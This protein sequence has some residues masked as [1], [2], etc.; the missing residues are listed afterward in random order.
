MK[1]NQKVAI[2]GSG[3]CGLY[4]AWKLSKQGHDISVFEK[5]KKIGKETCSGLFSKRILKFVPESKQLIQNRIDFVL[6]HFPKRTIKVRFSQKFFVMSHLDLDKLVASLAKRSGAKIFLNQE[7]R[8]LPRG[9]DQIIGCD[10]VL[11][12]VRKSLGIKNPSFRLAIQGFVKE[13]CFENFVEVWP[14]VN[15]GF[16]WR[17]PRGKEIEYGI[18]AKPQKAKEYFNRFL[19]KNKLSL[20]KIRSALVPQGFSIPH[21]PTVTLCGDAAGITKPWSGGGVIWGLIAADILLKH[22]PNFFNYQKAMKKFFLPKIIFSKT[23][24]TLVY[25]LGFNMPWILPQNIKMESDF[26]L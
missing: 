25:F 17:V 19:K 4:L 5:R 16:I 12:F 1:K 23:I 26:L 22:F 24:I 13:E 9:F 7:A 20:R 8:S 14:L 6:V 3:I 2:I 15:Q 21:H 18:I 11:S 10:G